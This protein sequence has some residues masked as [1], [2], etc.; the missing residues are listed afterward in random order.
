MGRKRK[1]LMEG[2]LEEKEDQKKRDDEEMR[3]KRKEKIEGRVEDE[4]RRKGEDKG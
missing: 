3:I 2:I 4:W 1:R